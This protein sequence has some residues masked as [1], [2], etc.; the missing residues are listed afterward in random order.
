MVNVLYVDDEIINLELFKLT[1]KSDF[2]IVI[3][4]SAFEALK[5]LDEQNID[6]II[7]DFR[8]P[9]MNG[10]ELINVVK[11]KFPNKQCI[12]LTGYYEAGLAED[13]NIK[14]KVYK[15]MRKPFRKDELKELI[16]SSNNLSNNI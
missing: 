13:P 1:Y 8:M 11:E 15:Y 16:I 3:A 10:I 5:I 2:F 14:E 4:I 6:I 7:T 12:L 9:G